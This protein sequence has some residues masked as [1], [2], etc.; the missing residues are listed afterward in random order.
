MLPSAALMPPCAATVWLRVGNTFVM[1]AVDKARLGE[2]HRRTQTRAAGADHDDVEAVISQR[3]GDHEPPPVASVP[4][5]QT[6]AA[7]AARC[8]HREIQRARGMH[9]AGHI[10]VDH[11]L[12]A[13]RRMPQRA[14]AEQQQQACLPADSQARRH[15]RMRKIGLRQERRHEPDA[16]RHERHCADALVAPVARPRLTVSSTSQRQAGVS[17]ERRA[18]RKGREQHHQGA[19]SARRPQFESEAGVPDEVPDPVEQVIPEHGER[20]SEQHPHG[21]ARER[22]C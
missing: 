8:K 5:A 2:S 6:S 21:P 7:A 22:L 18:E 10:V 20:A 13:L 14:P 11:D 17:A 12:N 19:A 4:I 9:A 1:Q 15:R 16:E 3:I